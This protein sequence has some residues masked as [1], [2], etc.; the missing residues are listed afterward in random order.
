MRILRE[1]REGGEWIDADVLATVDA[2][3]AAARAYVE[4]RVIA[5]VY[6]PATSDDGTQALPMTEAVSVSGVDGWLSTSAVADKLGCGE[7]NVVRLI[8][9]KRLA[10]IRVGRS[11]LV[12]PA[13]LARFMED[14]T[15]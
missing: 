12:D 15:V 13:E 4:A 8:D 5:S 2:I 10:S 7:R 9:S 14:R 1:A 3:A 11:H 6:D